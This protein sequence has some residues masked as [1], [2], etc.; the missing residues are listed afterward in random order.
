VEVESNYK[1]KTQSTP[2][3]KT[4]GLHDCKT[5]L[6]DFT[7]LMPLRIDSEK[8]KENT[9]ASIGF[10]L[11][12][13]ETTFIV[14]EGDATRN[15]YPDFKASNFRYEFVEDKNEFF[16]KTKYINRLIAL[17]DT[18]YIAVWDTDAIVPPEQVSESVEVLRKGDAIMSIPYDGRVFTCDKYLSDFFKPEIKWGK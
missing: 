14:V 11:R 7:F 9:D 18:Q 10:I 2:D 1:N 6:T 12:H 5:D 17:A 3:C 4:A 15:Y 13:F 8:R 16:H